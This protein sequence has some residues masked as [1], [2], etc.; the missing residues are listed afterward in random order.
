MVTD[1]N[2]TAYI[3]ALGAPIVALIALGIAYRQWRVAKAK[4]VLDLFE[5]R[6]DVCNLV[7]GAVSDII[8]VGPDNIDEKI[9]GTFAAG[10]VK[11]KFLFGNEVFEF[12][13]A[14][15]EKIHRLRLNA[16][17]QDRNLNG[18]KLDE[19][20]DI[21]EK[22]FGSIMTFRNDLDRMVFP[23]MRMDEKK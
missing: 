6:L 20:F 10:L 8:A 18:D 15:H 3:S 23:Y 22:I 2:W 19:L 14:S 21:E 13:Q 1:P 12:L 7:T 11:S 5:K 16:R 9:T 4:V 17:K